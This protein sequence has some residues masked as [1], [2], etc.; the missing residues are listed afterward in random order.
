M[1]LPE[2][3]SRFARWEHG[4]SAVLRLAP[5]ATLLFSAALTVLAT[6][7]SPPGYWAPLAPTLA[8][9]AGTVLW[10][11]YMST[12]HPDWAGHRLGTVY[13]V[14]LL[15]LAAALVSR[16]PWYGFFAWIGYIQTQSYLRGRWRYVG[17][18]ATALVAAYAQVGSRPPD[19]LLALAGYL[20]VA[21][22]NALLAGAFSVISWR[23][24]QQNQIRKQ[25]VVELAEANS[26]L[27]T[28]M[29]ENVGLHAQL[30]TQARE[31][32]VLDE[33]QR[34]AGEIHDTLAQGLIGIVAQLEAAE[35][36]RD[37][38]A[39]WQ[40][41]LDAA[42]RLAR[43]SLTEARR[44]VQAL[45]PEPLEAARLPEALTEVAGRWSA[46]HGPAAEV[47][48]TGTARPLHPEVEVALLRT[49]QEALSNVAKHAA[50]SRVGL[51]LSYMDDQVTLDVRDDGAGFTP[52]QATRPAPAGRAGDTLAGGFGLTAM[53]QRLQRLAGRLEIESE[54]GA[55]TAI[56]A[57]I[58]TQP[59]EP[60]QLPGPA[61]DAGAGPLRGAEPAGQPPPPPSPAPAPAAMAPAV[62]LDRPALTA[63]AGGGHG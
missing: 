34:M 57:S 31:A 38:P 18:G 36:A 22:F 42:A 8:L 17:I 30:V 32:G 35:Q 7:L 55:G 39:E 13:Y 14:G 41:H 12:L 53:R 62:A 20:A 63:A 52:G 46:L 33:R 11:L 51:T 25:M 48:T 5:Y 47:V 37:C 50:A 16:A 28:T 44:S 24:E 58:P 61:R 26:R 9:T 10:V 43:E 54:P 49:A 6:E 60:A 1:T 27:A 2:Q 23:V 29:Q 15:I 3:D 45:R 21:S 40:R 4:E 56:S 59:I 19:S